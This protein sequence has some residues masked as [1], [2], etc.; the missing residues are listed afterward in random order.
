[1]DDLLYV[2][3]G[4]ER[5]DEFAKALGEKFILK[6]LGRVDRYL[7]VHI[8][9]TKKGFA[10]SQ[11]EKIEEL[12]AKCKM[13][14]SNPTCSPIQSDYYG[15]DHKDSPDFTDNKLYRSVIGSL[16]YI[17]NWSRPDIALAVNLLSRHVENPKEF[18][19][20]AVK[21][22]LRYLRGTADVLLMLE[23][24][25]GKPAQLSA[26]LDADWAGDTKSRR[27]TSDF[28]ILLNVCPIHWHVRQ[29]KFVSCSTAKAE[30][31]SLSDMQMT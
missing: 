10:L 23:P 1:M 9:A 13:A 17:S 15:H 14:E 30:Y 26:Y 7:G 24:E 28:L 6:S 8:L 5:C 2:G 25:K 3:P 22:V 16:L 19:W 12:L 21:R 31:A 20:N 11:K 4:K 29:Q 18:H 27:S